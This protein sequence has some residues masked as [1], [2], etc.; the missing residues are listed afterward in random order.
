MFF[1]RKQ[2]MPEQNRIFLKDMVVDMGI[3]VF[4]EEKGRVQRVRL[5]IIVVPT[6]WPDESRDDISDTVSYDEIKKIAEGHA[7]GG[8]IHLVETLAERIARDC[9]N[10]LPLRRITVRVEKLDIYENVIPGV[11][12]IREKA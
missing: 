4:A 9:L 11:E 8:H 6:K 5:N 3:G 1:C 2:A 7:Q 12:I 10:T